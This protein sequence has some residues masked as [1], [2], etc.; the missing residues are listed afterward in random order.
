MNDLGGY[1]SWCTRNDWYHEH[2]VAD[3]IPHDVSKDIITLTK[4]LNQLGI[5][6][7]QN[8][9]ENAGLGLIFMNFANR[10]TTGQ[11]YKSDLLLQTIIDNNLS[12]L[13]VRKVLQQLLHTMPATRV[14]A[15][16]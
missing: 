15:M 13:C 11:E 1:Y 10:G 8:R 12:L 16:Q 3:V 9:E 4:D 6:E 14:A 7:L 5:D 2:D